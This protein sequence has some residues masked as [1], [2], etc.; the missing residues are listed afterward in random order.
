MH[1]FDV[2]VRVN[3]D[4]TEE[5]EKGGLQPTDELAREVFRKMESGKWAH[6]HVKRLPHLT[7]GDEATLALWRRFRDLSIDKY[8]DLYGRL[9]VHF[10]IYAGESQVSEQEIQDAMS[11]LRAKGLLSTKTAKESKVGQWKD[12]QPEAGEVEDAGSDD[13]GLALAVDLQ[14]WKLGKPVV[15]KAGSIASCLFMPPLTMLQMAHPSTSC[16]TSQELA[17]GTRRMPRTR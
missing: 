9:N 10:D 6:I 2:Y 14:E 13:R 3:R 11:V 15:Q 16:A 1:L 5:V 7:P 4:L 8:A 12:K 17:S